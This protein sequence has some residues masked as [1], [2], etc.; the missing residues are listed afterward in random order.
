[1][2]VTASRILM[3]IAPGFRTPAD[4]GTENVKGVIAYYVSVAMTNLFPVFI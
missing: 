1:M 2:E 4:S 3:A